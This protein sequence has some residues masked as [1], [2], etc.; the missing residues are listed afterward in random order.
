MRDH[1]H[2]THII[3]YEIISMMFVVIC[4]YVKSTYCGH[5]SP[6]SRSGASV[7]ALLIQSLMKSWRSTEKKNIFINLD[8]AF[9]GIE[10]QEKIQRATHRSETERQRDEQRS[11]PETCWTF[12]YVVS[13][14]L[15][16]DNKVSDS[17]IA[18]ITRTH[19]HNAH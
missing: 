18:I 3:N 2:A 15:G 19:F 7:V 13:F 4:F 12:L 11:E 14:V 5:F 17:Y 16:M 6:R 1:E 8:R 10:E 9:D